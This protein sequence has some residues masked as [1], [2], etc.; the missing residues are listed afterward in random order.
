ME[1]GRVKVGW[2]EGDSVMEGGRVTVGW[3]E[4]NELILTCRWLLASSC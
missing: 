1:G 2:R 4:G 3:R